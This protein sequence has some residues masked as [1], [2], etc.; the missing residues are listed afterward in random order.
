MY[1][2]KKSKT[3]MIIQKLLVLKLIPF[4]LIVYSFLPLKSDLSEIEKQFSQIQ[5]FHTIAY[6]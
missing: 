4:A 5:G 1:Q 3:Q 6:R 2:I